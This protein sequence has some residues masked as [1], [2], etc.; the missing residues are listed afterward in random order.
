MAQHEGVIFHCEFNLCGNVKA[1]VPFIF[2]IGMRDQNAAEMQGQ[3][4]VWK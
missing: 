2:L 1:P 3:S 4:E